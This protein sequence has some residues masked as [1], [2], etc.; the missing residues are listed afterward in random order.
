MS[1]S[2]NGEGPR[3]EGRAVLVWMKAVQRTSRAKSRGSKRDNEAM[4]VYLW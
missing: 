1:K 3:R 4:V 2:T